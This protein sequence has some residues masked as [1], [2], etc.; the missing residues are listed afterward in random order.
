MRGIV[1]LFFSPSLSFSFISFSPIAVGKML[2]MHFQCSS[3]GHLKTCFR[4]NS[5]NRIAIPYTA[6]HCT[7]DMVFERV[8]KKTQANEKRNG[9]VHR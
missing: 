5:C 4:A 6:P 1:F 8:K 3:I 9:T 7:V 2:K